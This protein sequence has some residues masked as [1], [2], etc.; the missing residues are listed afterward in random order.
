VPT[1]DPHLVANIDIAPTL[2][3]AAGVVPPIAEDG[4]SMLPL[5]SGTASSWRTDLLLEGYDDPAKP[6]G[7]E[8]V[9]TYCGLRTERYAYFRYGTGEEELYDLQTDPYEMTNLLF[10]NTD[11]AIDAL[12][13]TLLTRLKQLCSPPPPHYTI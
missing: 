13:A 1:S 2:A 4:A 12:H 9:P 11:P 3:A 10:H 6:T 8:Y 5:L 7:G